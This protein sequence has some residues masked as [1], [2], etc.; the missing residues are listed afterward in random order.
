VNAFALHVD[1]KTITLMCDEYMDEPTVDEDQIHSEKCTFSYVQFEAF[2]EVN[3]SAVIVKELDYEGE[4]FEIDASNS[5]E[6][7]EF[8]NSR[9]SHLPRD[10]YTR[11]RNLKT[12]TCDGVNLSS[13]SKADF[14]LALNL[15]N[16]SCNSNYV[17][18]LEKMLFN[19]SKRLQML[20]LSINEIEDI[21]RTTFFGLESLK[22]L[23]LHDN[24]LQKLSEDVFEDLI[25]LEEINLSSNQLAVVDEN[26]FANCKLL[27]Y[28]YLNDNRIQQISDKLLSKIDEIK[29][30]ELS[31]NELS[32]LSLNVSASA[33]YAN[34]NLL[35][36]VKLKSV[37]YLSFY[38]N[39]IAELDF[40]DKNGVISLNISTNNFSSLKSIADMKNMKSLDLS[41]NN[42]GLLNVSTFLDMPQL[43]ILNLQSTNLAEIGFGLFTH[44]TSLEQLDLSYNRLG[45]LEL[46]K[47][48][49][50]KA[51]TTLFVEGNNFTAIDFKNIKTILPNLT[52]FG[53]SDNPWSCAYLST[54]I[55]SL[56]RDNIEIF[57]LVTEKM[58][59]NVDGIACTES[60]KVND[61][62]NYEDKSLSVNPIKHHRLVSDG[63]EMRAISE[64]FEVVLRNVNESSSKYATKA[65][66]INELNLIKNLVA[67]LKQDMHEAKHN[68]NLTVSDI[69][70]VANDTMMRQKSNYDQKINGLSMKMESVEQSIDEIRNQLKSPSKSNAKLEA[71][72]G[73]HQ[74]S[75][76]QSPPTVTSDDS[77]T[78]LMVSVIFVIACGF[79]IIYIIKLY[80]RRNSRKFMVRRA[81]SDNETLNENIL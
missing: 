71:D 52:L 73:K 66:L 46:V 36:T 12:V 76:I 33:L 81:C 30:L 22:K 8:V 39:S 50:L 23:M 35:K 17:K 57:H 16:F 61:Q 7:V 6:S 31:N 29:F 64:K 62:M 18:L 60:E 67:S 55:T 13:L 10:L 32:N 40:E 74:F 56:H 1:A 28:I 15:E 2:D 59:S 3:I 47:L 65:E 24:K 14:K 70:R 43:Q 48:M 11:F 37:G 75:R 53:F 42:L 80:S 58:K 72:D 27:N 54:L 77:V 25:S 19:G 20:D 51:L 68:D 34:H 79:T 4:A 69:K 21:D 26:L 38:N 49:P 44:Q 78:K 41:F 63:N 5:I 9:F 45:G